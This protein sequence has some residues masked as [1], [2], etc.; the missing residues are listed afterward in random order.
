MAASGSSRPPTALTGASSAGSTA[1]IPSRPNTLPTTV[2][3]TLDGQEAARVVGESRRV[4]HVVPAPKVGS[5]MSMSARWRSA[6]NPTMSRIVST[7]QRRVN[8]SPWWIASCM[9]SDRAAKESS[10]QSARVAK[11]RTAALLR[12]LCAH[13]VTGCYL[14]L[15][16]DQAHWASTTERRCREHLPADAG[17][18]Q[19]DGA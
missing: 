7:T 19:R 13:W 1:A 17:G 11:G 9:D 2:L 18:A 10:R 8:T 15:S 12:H 4:C 14:D 16:L 6:V 5:T 3:S